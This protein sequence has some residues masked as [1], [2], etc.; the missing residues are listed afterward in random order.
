MDRKEEQFERRSTTD[1]TDCNS[2]W[3]LLNNIF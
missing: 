1:Y 2:R 3:V